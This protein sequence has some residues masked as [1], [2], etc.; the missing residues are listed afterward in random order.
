MHEVKKMINTL[1]TRNHCINR[2]IYV[3]YGIVPSNKLPLLPS[4]LVFL[5]VHRSLSSLAWCHETY[6]VEEMFLNE[7]RSK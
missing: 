5:P 6:E 4:I 2:L 1:A 7:I 3:N